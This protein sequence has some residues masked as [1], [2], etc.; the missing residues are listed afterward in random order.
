[1]FK[2]I[3]T[4][5][6][7]FGWSEGN[8][9]KYSL[10]I[11]TYYNCSHNP[12]SPMRS[13]RLICPPYLEPG[14]PHHFSLVAFSVSN[15]SRAH[16]LKLWMRW[17]ERIRWQKRSMVKTTRKVSW[18]ADFTELSWQRLALKCARRRWPIMRTNAQ[19]I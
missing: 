3:V 1:M 12:H 13:Q 11:C 10:V 16:C 6:V 19:S 4:Y 15:T 18:E 17:N 14:T 9:F 5:A 2:D 8:E 7:Y